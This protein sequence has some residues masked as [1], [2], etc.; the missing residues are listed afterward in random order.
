M[1]EKVSKY[2]VSGITLSFFFPT[3]PHIERI[4][5]VMYILQVFTLNS[6]LNSAHSLLSGVE[7]CSVSDEFAH[8]DVEGKSKGEG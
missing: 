8:K 4:P 3:Y 1:A 5:H 7:T 6:G 2:N